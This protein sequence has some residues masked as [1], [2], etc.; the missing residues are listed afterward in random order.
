MREAE[1]YG[2]L[3]DLGN[4]TAAVI[5]QESSYCVMKTWK[6]RNP[7]DKNRYGCGQL[8]QKTVLYSTGLHVSI[9]DLRNDDGLNMYMVARILNTCRYLFG[10]LPRLLYCYN[11]GI[12]AAYMASEKTVNTSHYY[13]AILRRL[14]EVETWNMLY[15]FRFPIPP[16]TAN[17]N[18]RL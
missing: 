7:K 13:R 2:Q 9:K 15:D 18:L 10:N 14:R 11:H 4:V 17:A 16:V 6:Y 8:S 1:A 3:F 5:G 12:G